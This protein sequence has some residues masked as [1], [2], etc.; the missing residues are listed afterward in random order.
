MTVSHFPVVNGSLNGITRFLA[1]RSHIP[2][3]HGEG[4]VHISYDS[5]SFGSVTAVIGY[6]EPGEDQC[7]FVSNSNETEHWYQIDFLSFNVTIT[8]YTLNMN[9]E[10]YHPEWSLYAGNKETELVKVDHQ[11][12]SSQPQNWINTYTLSKSVNAQ[13]FRLSVNSQRFDPYWSLSITELEFFGSVK[14]PFG[15]TCKRILHLSSSQISCFL[16]ILS[17]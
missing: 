8:G 7:Y 11:S 4:V 14:Y 6:C 3:L 17:L 2:N 1:R 13:I 10:H 15:E 16:L 5:F 9:P 12:I